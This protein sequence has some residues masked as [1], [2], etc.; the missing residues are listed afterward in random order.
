[1]LPT[2]VTNAT[3]VVAPESVVEAALVVLEA[4]VEAVELAVWGVDVVDVVLPEVVVEVEDELPPH[5]TSER[6]I[7]QASTNETTFFIVS[8]F[9]NKS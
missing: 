5:A 3:S 7:A 9:G 4:A 1:M 8:S 6:D 2:S